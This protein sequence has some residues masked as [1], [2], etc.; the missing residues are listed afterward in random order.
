M[1]LGPSLIKIPNSSLNHMKWNS[2]S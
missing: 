2:V 1:L